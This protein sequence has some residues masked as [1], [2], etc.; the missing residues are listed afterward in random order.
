[1]DRAGDWICGFIFRGVGSGRLVH[2]MGT[3][4]GLCAV[5]SL[6]DC[7]RARIT[8]TAGS[9]HHRIVAGSVT[10]NYTLANGA[11]LLIRRLMLKRLSTAFLCSLA[12]AGQV[13]GQEVVVARQ[14]KPEASEQATRPPQRA[15]PELRASTQTKSHAPKDKSTSPAPTLVHMRLSASRRA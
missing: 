13:S 10:C 1:M 6:S 8:D 2:A 14:R 12:I 3:Q 5:C 9:R 7:T 15:E 4:E 11:G